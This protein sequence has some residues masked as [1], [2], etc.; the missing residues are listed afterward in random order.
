MPEWQKG[1]VRGHTDGPTI[2]VGSRCTTV[3]RI[4]RL[5]PEVTSEITEYDPPR[6]WVTGVSM[7][8]S[9]PWS[10]SR[11]NRFLTNRGRG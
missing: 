11:L 10:Q 2:R 7:V 5:E 6:R 8:R 3:R 1:C 9:G 4:G